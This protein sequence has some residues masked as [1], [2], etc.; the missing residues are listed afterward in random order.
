MVS[1]LPRAANADVF[2]TDNGTPGGEY[3]FVADGADVSLSGGWWWEENLD[4][5]AGYMPAAKTKCRS[6]Q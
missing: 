6:K 4:T 1:R 3:D 2:M 5:R